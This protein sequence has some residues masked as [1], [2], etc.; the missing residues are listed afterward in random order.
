M[1]ARG[2]FTARA[3][4]R[5]LP[6]TGASPPGGLE[7]LPETATTKG[8]PGPEGTKETEGPEGTNGPEGTKGPE[9]TNGPEGIKG[10]EK[11]K[12]PEGTR[13]LDGLEELE[14]LKELEGLAGAARR[15]RAAA[16]RG[17]SKLKRGIASSQERLL[18]G[19]MQNSNALTVLYTYANTYAWDLGDLGL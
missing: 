10:P 19:A 8:S 13:G 17:V 3:R 7:G 14:D 6:A 9:G 5:I 18:C 1:Y 11:T 2:S 15:M 4:A 12:G 16:L